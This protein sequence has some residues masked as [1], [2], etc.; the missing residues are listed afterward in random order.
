MTEYVPIENCV[1]ALSRYCTNSPP[2]DLIIEG[3]DQYRGWF[4]SLLW[5]AAAAAEAD[6]NAQVSPPYHSLLVHGF[7]VD[8]DGRKMSKSEGNVIEPQQ[9]WL[10]Y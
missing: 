7:V 6:K 9:V 2:A 3:V 1:R 8:A 5:T 4:Q 10:L